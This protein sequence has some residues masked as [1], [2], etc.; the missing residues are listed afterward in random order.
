M[1]IHTVQTPSKEA[2]PARKRADRGKEDGHIFN[3]GRTGSAKDGKAD[4]R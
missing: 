2:G 3:V 1:V 4:E